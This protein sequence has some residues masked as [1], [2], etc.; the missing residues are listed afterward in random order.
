MTISGTLQGIG[1]GCR[2]VVFVLKNPRLRKEKYLRIFI[3]LSVLS[4][5]LFIITNILVALPIQLVRFAIWMI[6][7]SAQAIHGSQSVLMDFSRSAH[8]V[9]DMIPMI[10]LLFMRYIYPKPL[11]DLFMESLRYSDICHPERPAYASS[12]RNR[13]YHAEYWRNVVDY[14]QRMTK[15]LR[16]MVL[17]PLLFIPI[18]GKIVFSAAGAYASILSLGRTQGIMIG[19][20]FLILPRYHTMTVFRAFISMRALMRELLE[21][22]FA[23]MNMTHSQKRQWCFARKDTLFGF[24][25]IAYLLARIPI[26]GFLGYAIAQAAAAYMVTIVTLPPSK[27]HST[28]INAIHLKHTK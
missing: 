11:D 9:A 23:R 24:S 14:V 21:P 15:K 12:L 13:R 27:P 6:A 2:G 5:L 17:Y 10:A 26:F 8:E 1:Y 19:I 25:A 3:R 7:P 4:F 20:C 22:Y 18:I 16:W 28:I